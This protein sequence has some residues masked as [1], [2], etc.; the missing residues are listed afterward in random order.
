MNVSVLRRL[1]T[2]LW[3]TMGQDRLSGLALMHI[4]YGMELDLDEIVNLF[5]RKHLHRMLLS[6]FLSSDT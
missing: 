4:Q 5:A 1:K 6:D 2:Y 3:S